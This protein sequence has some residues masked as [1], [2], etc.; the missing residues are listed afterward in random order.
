MT[1]A[2]AILRIP[3]ARPELLFPGD[4]TAVH[5][6]Y[7]RL[8][9]QWHPDRSKDP[10]AT[11]VFQRVVVLY[12]AAKERIAAG[13][14][15]EGRGETLLEAR[16]G[17]VY[18]VRHFARRQFE[19]GELLIGRTIAAFV[20][21]PDA[22]DL[23]ARAVDTLRAIEYASDEM[24]R[25]IQPCLPDIEATLEGPDGCA[26]VLGKAPDMVLL[27][28]L[29]AHLGGAVPAA[30]V[31]WILSS[32]YNLAC[33]LEWAQI[34]HNAVGPETVFVSP[35]RH[36]VALLGGWWYAAR[37]GGR[38]SALP[39]RTVAGIPPD[40]VRA[41]R[42]D[43]R[44]DLELIRATG[45]ELLGDPSGVHLIRN[46]AVPHALADWLR[47]PSSGSA[48]TDYRLWQEVIVASFGAR[49]FSRLDLT[50]EEIYP[51]TV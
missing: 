34:A 36:A 12:T 27:A 45:R 22:A 41:R 21:R 4:E 44:S 29:A 13:R 26:L 43:P 42:A 11:E 33:W 37:A 1:S 10:R 49:R 47:H 39:A 46:P 5:Q 9:S 19:L 48:I 50:P 35:Q 32:L 14:W 51:T 38:L 24:R 2:E 30:H 3:P 20:V 15:H 16:D 17:R 25:Q 8:A 6:L 18:R 31:A 40:I 28:D 23:H 7:H